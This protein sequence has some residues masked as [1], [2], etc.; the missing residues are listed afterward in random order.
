M[1]PDDWNRL[2]TWMD[3]YGQRLGS[4]DA[5]QEQELRALRVRMAS[6]LQQ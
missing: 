4:F 2:I 5:Q 3:A 6:M 1:E